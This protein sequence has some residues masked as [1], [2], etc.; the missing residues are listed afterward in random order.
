MES[1]SS[2]S[3]TTPEL[4]KHTR[5]ERERGSWAK[6]KIWRRDQR[7][8]VMAAA[9]SP[10]TKKSQGREEEEEPLKESW[11]PTEGWITGKAKQRPLGRS[12]SPFPPVAPEAQGGSRFWRFCSRSRAS[13]N[14]QCRQKSWPLLRR[15][16]T[17]RS[18]CR[19]TSTFTR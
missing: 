10:W 7:L 17:R 1:P 15:F 9:A 18:W 11:S 19:R 3:K 14:S 6:R 2:G 8:E 4:D 13:R 5:T 12:S 16:W